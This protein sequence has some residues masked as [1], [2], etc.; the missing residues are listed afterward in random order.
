MACFNVASGAMPSRPV[1]GRL[2]IT[3]R[4]AC[5]PSSA[6]LRTMSFSEMM[7]TGASSFITTSAA[8]L[9]ALILCAAAP[10]VS[11]VSMVMTASFLDCRSSRTF[12]LV[13]WCRSLKSKKCALPIR[14]LPGNRPFSAR[15][16]HFAGSGISPAGGLGAATRTR[17]I[18]RLNPDLGQLDSTTASIGH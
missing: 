14:P 6:R 7:P 16:A 4:P 18:Q 5:G 11:S 13:S 17:R 15:L 1:D 12:I 8:I 2:E 9:F 10:I 3:R